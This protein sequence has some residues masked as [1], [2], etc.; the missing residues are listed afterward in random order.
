MTYTHWQDIYRGP[1]EITKV[2]ETFVAKGYYPVALTSRIPGSLY[3]KEASSI[4][5]LAEE[6]GIELG[7][8][9][10]VLW[11][12]APDIPYLAYAMFRN[13]SDA[14]WAQLTLT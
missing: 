9:S 1:L 13:E 2:I 8:Y 11:D 14:L 12:D 5:A 7:E 10:F 4:S 6:H 3:R